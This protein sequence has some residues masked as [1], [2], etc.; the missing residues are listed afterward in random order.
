MRTEIIITVKDKR[1]TFAYDVEVPTNIST[2]RAARDI[3]HVLE[4]ALGRQWISPKCVYGLKN[5]R[6]GAVLAPEKSLYEN[7]VWQGDVLTFMDE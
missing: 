7:G 3:T 5:E 2:Q 6:T 1:K 4:A